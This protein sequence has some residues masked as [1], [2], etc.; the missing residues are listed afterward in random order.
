MS[1]RRSWSEERS[2]LFRPSRGSGAAAPAGAPQNLSPQNLVGR[3]FARQAAPARRPAA[4]LAALLVGTLVAALLATSLRVDI[5][6][7]RYALGEAVKE[8]ASLLETSRA[9]TVARRELRDPRHLRRLAEER[10]FVRPARVIRLDDPGHA[11]SAAVTAPVA[12]E[13]R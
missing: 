8:E 1:L 13:P 3:D 2:R 12:T 11:G 6:R 5:L 9:L 7:L 10:G 4:P